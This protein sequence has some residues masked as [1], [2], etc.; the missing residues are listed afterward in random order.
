[1]KKRYYLRGLGIGIFITALIMGLAKGDGKAMTDEEVRARALELG[2]VEKKTLADV[3]EDE[4]FPTQNEKEDAVSSEETLVP[5][6][7]DLPQLTEA[8]EE[9][10]SPQ[11]TE[12]PKLT[13]APEATQSPESADIPQDDT[14]IVLEIVKGESSESISNKL[15]ELG[16][17]SNAGS[18]NK[19]LCEKG[20]DKR[21]NFGIY[22]I[23]IGTSEEEIAKIITRTR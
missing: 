15:M 7:T 17:I 3:R 13:E 10:I 16:L 4:N 6:E 14:I 9:T 22:K 8:P 1:M 18:Y 5:V 19:Y 12:A 23:Q 11:I 21:L 20:Y 2:M